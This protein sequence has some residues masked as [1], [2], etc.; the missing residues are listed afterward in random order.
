MN[1]VAA[2]AINVKNTGGTEMRFDRDCCEVEVKT[3]PRTRLA[4]QPEYAEPHLPAT[5]KQNHNIRLTLR[6][7][8]VLK[9]VKEAANQKPTKIRLH[10]KDVVGRSYKSKWFPID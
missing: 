7:A 1:N 5:I 2:L 4:V 6:A 9:A 10:I 8:S 3:R